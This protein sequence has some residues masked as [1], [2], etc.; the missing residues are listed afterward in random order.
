[1]ADFATDPAGTGVFRTMKRMKMLPMLGVL[2][3]LGMAMPMMQ[4][5]EPA[6]DP[7]A[8]PVAPPA[9]AS[10]GLTAVQR[11]NRAP[12]FNVRMQGEWTIG[13]LVRYVRAEVSK[14]KK[15]QTVNIVLGPGVAELKAPADLDLVNVTPLGVFAAIATVEPRLSFAPVSTPGSEMTIALQLRPN[16]KT[17][18]AGKDIKLR[19]FKLPVPRLDPKTPAEDRDRAYKEQVE[20]AK[21]LN[22][23][24]TQLLDIAFMMRQEAGGEGRSKT[25]QFHTHPATRTVLVTGTGDDLDLAEEVLT[26]LGAT[27]A[28]APSPSADPTNQKPARAF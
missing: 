25:F 26:A 21:E 28:N 19:A 3:W 8:A 20:A 4:A 15:A 10:S 5:Q 7:A 23:S 6:S 22:A 12:V 17:Q 16:A 1:M 24:I 14:D 27:A 18:G 13:D 11:A 9:G 2:G